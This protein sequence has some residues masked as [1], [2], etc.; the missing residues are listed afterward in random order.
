[1]AGRTYGLEAKVEAARYVFPAVAVVVLG[2]SCWRVESGQF[3]RDRAA[4]VGAMGAAVFW[5]LGVLGSGWCF[6][7]HVCID[8][9]LAHPPYPGWHQCVDVGWVLGLVVASLW[10]RRIRVS[11]GVAFAGVGAFLISYRF[12]LG[13]L[14]GLYEWLPL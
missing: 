3:R 4:K 13:S 6:S 2:F 14:G 5:V 1:L 10:T 12:L 9:H 7:R 11:L 8:G